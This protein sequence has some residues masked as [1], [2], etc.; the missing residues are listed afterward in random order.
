MLS[1]VLL[2][3]LYKGLVG[4]QTKMINDMVGSKSSDLD[5]IPSIAIIPPITSIRNFL[6]PKRWEH[7]NKPTKKFTLTLTSQ[8]LSLTASKIG[9]Y[10]NRYS[11]HTQLRR[12][13]TNVSNYNYCFIFKE[14][15]TMKKE[16]AETQ[17]EVR[18]LKFEKQVC[19]FMTFSLKQ[20]KNKKNNLNKEQIK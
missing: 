14:H 7:L 20:E 16:I 1:S 2:C 9:L 15:Q 3:L 4:V 18:D 10:D 5:L 6:Q 11:L 8:S 19:N 17:R 12:T 13:K